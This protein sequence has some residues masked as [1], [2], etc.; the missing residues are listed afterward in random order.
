MIICFGVLK[1]TRRADDRFSPEFGIS[2]INSGARNTPTLD[3][4]GAAL[5]S[6]MLKRIA[7]VVTVGKHIIRRCPMVVSPS[8]FSASWSSSFFHSPLTYASIENFFTLCPSLIYSST[9]KRLNVVGLSKS[10]VK[11]TDVTS[12]S[13]AQYVVLL[14]STTFLG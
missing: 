8:P 7:V 13:V 3:I 9:R 2:G 6:I 11:E 12:S 5:L 10:K 4:I 14:S 1:N